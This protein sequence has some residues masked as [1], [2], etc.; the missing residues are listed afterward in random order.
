MSG[1]SIYYDFSPPPYR[2]TELE[3]T[4]WKISAD[5]NPEATVNIF[6]RDL[7]TRWSSNTPKKSGHVLQIDLGKVVPDLGRVTLLSGKAE[8]IPRGLRLEISQDGREWQIVREVHGFWGDLFWSGPH[9]FY[10]PY[11]GRMD[12]IFVPH[13]GRYLRLTQL[14]NDA[15]YSWSVAECFIYQAQPDI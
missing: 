2:F 10:R 9:P 15:S 12:I 13:G 11:E 8:E 14:G 3:P 5:S 7:T 4:D 1:Y 6:D